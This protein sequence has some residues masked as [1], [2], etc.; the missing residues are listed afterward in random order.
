MESNVEYTYRLN[1][2][3][4]M[5]LAVSALVGPQW[6]SKLVK[7]VQLADVS[8]LDYSEL[9]KLFLPT[10]SYGLP[11]GSE[12]TENKV[13]AEI[14]FLEKID[15]L[16]RGPVP[17]D[18]GKVSLERK[19]TLT[20]EGKRLAQAIASGRT[21]LVRPPKIEQNV[22]F[23]AGAFGRTDIDSLY[24]REIVPACQELGYLP[25]RVD[26][27]EPSQ[28]ITNSILS[29]IQNSACVLADL[30]YAR[31]SVYFEVGFAHGLGIPLVLTCKE[32]HLKGAKDELK[33]HFDLVQYKT[34]FW[35]L[36]EKG[37]FT[38]K[39][40]RPIERL[41]VYL[42]KPPTASQAR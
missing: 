24:T 8:K 23:F 9:L 14:L 20:E 31:P 33:I 27:Y 32:D 16:S 30:S 13:K 35:T 3:Q 6:T 29:G 36:G 26:N 18:G 11:G 12:Y 28:T 4:K 10:Y 42:G 34:S 1:K 41:R 5:I 22:V 15:L 39:D 21:P 19:M 40:K 38:W 7:A 2:L 37:G 17:G 25:F